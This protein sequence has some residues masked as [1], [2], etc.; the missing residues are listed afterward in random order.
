M[1]LRAAVA[2]AAAVADVQFLYFT[3]ER[4]VRHHGQEKT[5]HTVLA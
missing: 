4:M 1:K 5:N 2:L 3:K